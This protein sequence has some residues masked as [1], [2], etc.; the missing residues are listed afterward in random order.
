MDEPIVNAA[1]RTKKPSMP[2]LWTSYQRSLFLK[3]EP[4]PL[5]ALSAKNMPMMGA[6]KIIR[7]MPP[8][9][10]VLTEMPNDCPA[11][12][13][14]MVRATASTRYTTRMGFQAIR[15]ACLAFGSLAAFC[16]DWAMRRERLPD[17]AAC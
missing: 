15:L 4:P 9:K 5:R 14:T 3:V 8:A 16:S 1:T 10:P 2:S 6:M 13:D 12:S 17:M 11:N 7:Q